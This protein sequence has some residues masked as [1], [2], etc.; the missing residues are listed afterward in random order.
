VLGEDLDIL[1]AVAAFEFVLD[2]EVREVHT[3]IEVRKVVFT[4]PFFDLARVPIR[5]PVTVRPTAVVFL[6]KALVFAFDVLLEDHAANLRALFTETLLRVEVGAIERGIV[7]QLTEPA[8]AGME[9]LVPGTAD[10]AAVGIEQPA[11]TRSQGDGA[12]A[13]VERH[14]PNQPFVS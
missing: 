5:A 8:D 13:S 4:G 12:L 3:V 6:E 9:P 10:V 11:S 14:G 1:A 2:P 7:R